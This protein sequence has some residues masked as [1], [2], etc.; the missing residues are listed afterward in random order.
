[1]VLFLSKG[2]LVLPQEQFVWSKLLQLYFNRT[3]DNIKENITD[4]VYKGETTLHRMP[5]YYTTSQP[6]FYIPFREYMPRCRA[7]L[8]YHKQFSLPN[9]AERVL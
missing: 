4:P 9:T 6:A 8:Q 1:M 2:W 7:S 3:K 5:Q